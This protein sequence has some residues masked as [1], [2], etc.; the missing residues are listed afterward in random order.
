MVDD[1]TD[2]ESIMQH[3]KAKGVDFTKIF[4]AHL[5]KMDYPNTVPRISKENLKKLIQI[6]HKYDLKVSVHVDSPAEM[7][8]AVECGADCIEHMIGAGELENTLSPELIAMTKKRGVVVD[9]TMISIKRY[10]PLSA[11][12]PIWEAVKR[13][14]RQCYDAGI[15]MV[16]GCDSGI[17]FVPF[18][19]SVHDEMACLVEA[20]I[21]P[22][23]VL[24]MATLGNARLLEMDDRIGTIEAGKDAD[25]LVLDA[26]PLE[27]IRNTKKIRLVLLRGK[28]V[29]DRRD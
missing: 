22:L 25:L 17:P 9:P 21:P 27:D 26:N 7:W 4:Y 11:A 19:E 3:F 13:A 6:S 1:D 5:N 14:V 24:S 2:I 23:E 20:G 29:T 15:P 28:V 8:D 12:T 16:V 18:G 10:D